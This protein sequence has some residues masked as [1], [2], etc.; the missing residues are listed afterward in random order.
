VKDAVKP[1]THSNHPALYYEDMLADYQRMERY[2]AAISQCVQPG[3]VVAD[4]GTG[5]GV[6]AMMAAQAG[7]QRVYAIDN[8]E[9]VLELTRKIITTNG[10]DDRITVICADAREV[11]TDEPVDLL[12]NELIGDFGTDEN[13]YEC[14]REFA[15]RNLKSNGR[16]LPRNLQTYLVPVQYGDEFRGIWRPDYQGLDM[17]AGLQVPTTP[18]PAMRILS[19]PVTELAA[20]AVLENIDFGL[21]MPDREMDYDAQFSIDQAGTLQGFMGY[22]V[23]ELAPDVQLRSHPAYPGC[24]WQTW[25][26]P[27]YPPLDVAVGQQLQTCVHARPNMIAPG[28]TM[29]WS[30]A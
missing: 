23:S 28:W 11:V 30:C 16:V 17:S 4:L 26:W 14:V 6:L 18:E 13:I 12:L 24:H 3:D 15:D 5:M 25:H 1:Y 10:L 21:G 9:F 19:Q 20:A 7:A 27:V 29:D 22:F 8:R 2:R